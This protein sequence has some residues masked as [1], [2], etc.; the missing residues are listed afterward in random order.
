MVNNQSSLP[1]GDGSNGSY[2]FSDFSDVSSL[3]LNGSAIQS[4]SILQLTGS[5]A[6]AGSA[7]ISSPISI[8]ANT[9]FKTNFEFKLHDGNG[10]Y[11]ADGITFILQNSAAGG[12][13][14]A[15]E[16]GGVGY[17]NPDSFGTPISKSLAVEFDTYKN[18]WDK[19]N[20]QIALL[21]DGDVT[22]TLAIAT[23]SF[24][25]NNG[26]VYDVWIDYDG[27]NNNLD[28]YIANSDVK[29]TTPLFSN[30]VDLT[31]ILGSQAFVG[32]SG[33]TGALFNAQDIE[34][35]SFSTSNISS[36]LALSQADYSIHENDK[37]IAVTVERTG[38]S[39]EAVAVK[40]TT[41]DRTA[42]AGIDYTFT[43][44]ILNFAEGQTQAQINIP[45]LDDSTLEP[46][47]AFLLTLSDPTGNAELGTQNTSAITLL[48]DDA[49]SVANVTTQHN[50]NNRTGA[51]LNEQ[52]LNTS[53]VNADQFG[54]LFSRPVDGSIYA[55]PLYLA[56]INIPNQGTHNVVYVATMH[57]TVYAFDAD[58]PNA[59]TPLWSTSLGASVKLPDINIGPENY[60]DIS[61][62]VGILSTPVISTT[63][64]VIYVVAL[65]KESGEYKYKLHALDLATGAENGE[66]AVISGSVSGTG[67]GSVNGVVTFTANRQNQR[68]GLLLSNNKIYIAFA[69]FG[70]EEPFHGWVF[71]YDATT[72]TQTAI[73]NDTPNGYF[74]GI[75]Q[76]GNGLST[77]SSGNIYVVTGN[78]SFNANG[79]QLG[80]SVVKFS[81]DLKVID[82]FS[83]YNGEALNAVDDDLG[84]AGALIVPNTNYLI[85]GGKEGKIYLLDQN[86]L[87]KFNASGDI[88]IP[89]SFQVVGTAV[90]GVEPPIGTGTH[91]IHGTPIYWDGPNGPEIYVW[92]ENDWARAYSFNGS[93]L[94]TTPTAI[95]S[96]TAPPGMPGGMLSL[97]ADGN[98]D[99]TGILWAYTPFDKDANQQV[100]SGILRALD[101]TT[102]TVLWDSKED[103]ARDDVGNFAKFS[104]PTIANGKVY[105]ST[106]SNNLVV[107][108]LQ[109]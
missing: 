16:G 95:S 41:S 109:T 34:S 91:N 47:R 24:Q 84:S 79:S 90:N 29:P 65:T 46:N 81:P 39:S 94:N 36:V 42:K 86:N 12:K 105:L 106:F 73:Y 50:N 104:P 80:N 3:T 52:L 6:Q 55:Q 25:L 87:G 89:Q 99:G 98:T 43:N 76:A 82:W 97:S 56:N 9:S 53:N 20:N 31:S 21:R 7:F 59:S 40:Y 93:T 15:G 75:W 67:G 70:D 63:N 26:N 72:L 8:D 92:G 2:R 27:S 69:S 57:N 28:V 48:D 51:D 33:G 30:Q 107:Y 17:G 10:L 85:A 13:A 101:P 62:E 64:N 77:D 11:G 60:K 100:V 14:L 23:P 58:D 108:G 37:A 83:P 49:T 1:N 32:F 35:W 45:V 5:S 103:A 71:A 19:S 4:D 18:S 74:G 44:G 68:P 78:G 38:S 66:P 54:K 88:Q 22:K 61:T 102:M 96:I